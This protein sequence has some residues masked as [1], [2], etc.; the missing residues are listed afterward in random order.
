MTIKPFI[1]A[2][3][4][5]SS[6]VLFF[7]HPAHAQAPNFAGYPQNPG[8]QS[9]MTMPTPPAMPNMPT[10]P[11]MPTMPSMPSA[12]QMP[13]APSFPTPQQAPAAPA[14]A[15]ASAPA[16]A[17]AKPAA[18]T[19]NTYVKGQCTW[20]V[21][22]K[23]PDLPNRLGNG[24]QWVKNAA[25]RGFSTGKTPK[26]GAV[27]EQPGH[28]A[29]VEAVNANGT[30]KISEM[31]YNGGVGVVHERTVSASKFTYIY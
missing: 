29:Y 4:V 30:V 11:Q 23:R 31:N 24:G 28:V 13:A 1:A 8:P 27:A 15:P 17:P 14:P 20:Y 26:V 2:I 3:A 12:P 21:K 16:A 18:D 7:A 5:V 22:N 19:T 9:Q 25:A 10:A 6:S